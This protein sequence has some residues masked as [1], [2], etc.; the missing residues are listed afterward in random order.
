MCVLWPQGSCELTST[1][2][3]SRISALGLA[4]FSISCSLVNFSIRNILS[5]PSCQEGKIKVKH[6]RCELVPG[7]EGVDQRG[8]P[9]VQ[10][11]CPST[12]LSTDEREGM[13]QSKADGSWNSPALPWVPPRDKP[14]PVGWGGVFASLMLVVTSVSLSQG[15]GLRPSGA[16]LASSLSESSIYELVL[17]GSPQSSY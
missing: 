15:L 11:R 7:A 4:L 16:L 6:G 8:V 12:V 9:Q 14:F 13:F 10:R 2:L 1:S 17:P 5:L 3:L